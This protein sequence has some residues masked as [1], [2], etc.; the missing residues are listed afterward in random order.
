MVF[1][2]LRRFWSVKDDGIFGKI[3]Q[4]LDSFDPL[5]NKMPTAPPSIPLCILEQLDEVPKPAFRGTIG[6]IYVSTFNGDKIA[7]KTV[8]EETIGHLRADIQLLKVVSLPTSFIN[9]NIP[10]MVEDICDHV[11]R[12]LKMNLELQNCINLKKLINESDFRSS[13]RTLSPIDALCTDDCFVYKYDNGIS[14]S[15][16]SQHNSKQIVNVICKNLTQLFLTAMFDSNTLIGDLN[17]GN[18][19]IC[20]S[21]QVVTILDYGCI[22][23]LT[24]E[25]VSLMRRIFFCKSDKHKLHQIVREWNGPEVIVDFMHQQTLPFWSD[26]SFGDIPTIDSLLSHPDVIKTKIPPEITMLFRAC[27]HLTDTLRRLDAHFSLL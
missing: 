11:T 13:F 9:A 14:M 21:T 8:L 24:D 20:K 6:S 1:E 4:H 7:I 25:Q 15:K 23:Y 22:I 16:F 12:E 27:S 10:T 3:N 19:L 26:C 5:I 18:V 17:E 2:L